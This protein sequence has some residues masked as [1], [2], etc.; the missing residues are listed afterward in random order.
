[1][2]MNLVDI[3]RGFP[4]LAKNQAV[5][6]Y[7]PINW[8]DAYEDQVREVMRDNGLRSMY[9]GPRVSNNSLDRASMTRRCDANFV[10]LYR[11]A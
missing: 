8:F 9:R 1:V 6:G 4:K 3:Q 2:I 7:I 10:V 11:K 5:T